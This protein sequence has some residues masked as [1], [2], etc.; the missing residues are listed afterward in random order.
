MNVEKVD[1]PSQLE[2]LKKTLSNK[3]KKE[4]G[5][6]DDDSKESENKEKLKKLLDGL[7][8]LDEGAS[9]SHLFNVEGEQDESPK[10][11]NQEEAIS[12]LDELIA[13]EE[14]AEREESNKEDNDN[15]K[16]WVEV[17]GRGKKK[18]E[19]GFGGGM[20]K[21]FFDSKS[22]KKKKATTV[23]AIPPPSALKTTSSFDKTRAGGSDNGGGTGVRFGSNSTLEIPSENNG[24]QVPT[25]PGHPP[26]PQP[27]L[28]GMHWSPPVL[29]Q[30]GTITEPQNDDQSSPFPNVP[31]TIP[32]RP[33]EEAGV[34]S[35]VVR[36]ADAGGKDYVKSTFAGSDMFTSSPNSAI[37]MR[38]ATQGAGAGVNGGKKL[39]KFA[40]ARL[41]AKNGL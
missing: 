24:H 20:K 1:L 29:N 26:K 39:S 5:D 22:P 4:D 10:V 2:D 30:D 17:T 31:T 32:N 37:G 16:D 21:G 25:L 3:V 41:D 35:G 23:P 8:L 13:L 6:S 18:K 34:F 38:H 27:T 9:T 7:S 28:S 36:G 11:G 40:Q 33:V 12:R 19:E 15:D 14:A